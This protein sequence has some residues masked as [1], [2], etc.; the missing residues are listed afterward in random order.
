[1]CLHFVCSNDRVQP[2]PQPTPVMGQLGHTVLDAPGVNLTLN[3]PAK[4]REKQPR[5]PDPTESLF[6]L[7]AVRNILTNNSDSLKQQSS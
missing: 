1:M 7:A 6:L 2:G 3:K 4:R 5:L